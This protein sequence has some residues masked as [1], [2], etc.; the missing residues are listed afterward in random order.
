MAKIMGKKILVTGGAG[1][2]GGHLVDELLQKDHEVIIYDNLTPQVHGEEQTIPPY[3]PKKC[4][5]LQK[6][7]RDVD[8][9]TKAIQEVDVIYHLAAEVGVGQSMYQIRKYVDA[10]TLGTGT[11]LDILVNQEHNVE[12]LVVASSMA[13]YGEGKSLCKACGTIHPTL[14]PKEQM[15]ARHWELICP[16]CNSDLVPVQTDEESP[17]DCTSIYALTKK[18]QEKMC[19]MIGKAY[20]INTTALRFFNVYG[21]HQALSNPYTGVCAIFSSAL[22]NGNAPIIYEDGLQTRDFVHVK[23]IVQALVLAM[24][25]P[26][27]KHEVF[28]VGTGQAFTIKQIAETLAE[29]V[30]PQITPVIENKFRL[31]DI[32]HCIADISK[33]QSMLGYSPKYRFEDGIQE[34]I[35]WVELQRGK[36]VDKSSVANK[37]LKEKGL[38]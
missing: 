22:L 18:D 33:I 7:V 28:N 3:V 29:H 12:K 34:L 21:S 15:E 11:L 24:E 38:L 9:L 16:S 26:E 23:D 35:S 25:K 32:R 17:Q 10:N 4:R 2:I 30:N 20:D 1:F 8:D 14:R 5:F 37:E 6:D 36:V 19:M 31:G 13:T 27:A